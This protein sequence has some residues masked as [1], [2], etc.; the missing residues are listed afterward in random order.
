MTMVRDI[1]GTQVS[2]TATIQL[3]DDGLRG[4]VHCDLA[5]CTAQEFFGAYAA[6]HEDLFDEPFEVN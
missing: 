4:A 5:P 6:A 3:M 2:F 1:H